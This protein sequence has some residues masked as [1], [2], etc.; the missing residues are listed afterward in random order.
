M[1]LHQSIHEI[2]E[3]CHIYTEKIIIAGNGSSSKEDNIMTFGWRIINI[4]KIILTKHAGPVFGQA[5]S[6]CAE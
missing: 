2:A 1:A 4:N 5:T 3:F 6:F